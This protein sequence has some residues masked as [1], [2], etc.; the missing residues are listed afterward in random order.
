MCTSTVLVSPKIKQLQLLGRHIN[1]FA[2][3]NDGIIGQVNRQ[4][5]IFHAFVV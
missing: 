1:I 4:I 2:K 3:V 5:R